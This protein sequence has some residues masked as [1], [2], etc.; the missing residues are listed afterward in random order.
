MASAAP[1]LKAALVTQL[2][3]LFPAPTVVAYGPPG[4][5]LDD[6]VVAVTDI[7]TTSQVH[8]S[9]TALREE[10]IDVTILFSVTNGGGAEIQQTVTER[11]YA[12]VASLEN[13]LKVTS[14]TVGGTVLGNAGVIA[15]ELTENA[16]N[17][18]RNAAL[19][20][21]VRAMAVG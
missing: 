12:M 15:T 2:A 17:G 20:V 9:T 7:T 1:A 21:M 14:P 11:A 8:T 6:E 16:P 13:Y 19:V 4:E 3:V 5:Y 18:S 10:V